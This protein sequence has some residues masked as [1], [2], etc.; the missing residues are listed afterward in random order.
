MS[1]TLA[2]SSQGV[3]VVPHALPSHTYTHIQ[4]VH[5][6]S[7]PLTAA[8]HVSIEVHGRDQLGIWGDDFVGK[9]LACRH[10]KSCKNLDRVSN[11]QSQPFMGGD[12]GQAECSRFSG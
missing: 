3:D 7:L 8:S 9:S 5:R 2:S 12:R 11:L 6:A 4:E 1:C 10:E